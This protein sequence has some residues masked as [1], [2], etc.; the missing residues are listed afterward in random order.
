MLQGIGAQKHVSIRFVNNGSVKKSI[1]IRLYINLIMKF[2]F[3]EYMSY[4]VIV[5]RCVLLLMKVIFIGKHM[6]SSLFL[7]TR[8]AFL[9][10]I[11]PNFSL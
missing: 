3:F 7:L 2:N 4:T 10:I 11:P 8:G 9:K 5:S 1:L 6:M